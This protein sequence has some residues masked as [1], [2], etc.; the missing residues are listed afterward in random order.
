MRTRLTPRSTRS[1]RRCLHRSSLAARRL[2]GFC[3]DP[4]PCPARRVVG[5]GRPWDNVSVSEALPSDAPDLEGTQYVLER[6]LG[7]GGFGQAYLAYNNGL[8][9]R[10][11]LKVLTD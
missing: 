10:C 9:R 3:R 11:V 6:L 8:K 5:H 7:E 4:L 1:R 2:D